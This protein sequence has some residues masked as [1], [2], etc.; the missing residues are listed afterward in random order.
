MY[1][2]IDGTDTM[3]YGM[4]SALYPDRARSSS[5]SPGRQ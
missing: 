1:V 5:S 3:E 4:L 2:L